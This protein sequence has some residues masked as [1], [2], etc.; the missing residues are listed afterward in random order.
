[1]TKRRRTPKKR[2]EHIPAV[3][4]EEEWRLLQFHPAPVIPM[5]I[6]QS[7]VGWVLVI[8]DLIS[9]VNTRR[10]YLGFLMSAILHRCDRTDW[11]SKQLRYHRELALQSCVLLA[12]LS[13]IL[14][15]DMALL[16]KSLDLPFLTLAC[17]RSDV[18]S[19]AAVTAMNIIMKNS[20][21]AGHLTRMLLR[22]I[23]QD[24]DLRERR[25]YYA[26]L[27]DSINQLSNM[28]HIKYKTRIQEVVSAGYQD[29]DTIIRK[30]ARLCSS[31]EGELIG[32]FSLDWLFSLATR[33]GTKH[34][35]NTDTTS[36]TAMNNL[37]H[38]HRN[39]PCLITR[40]EVDM[41]L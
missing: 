5:R 29:Q 39:Y 14:S 21:V 6:I 16:F 27:H 23:S 19:A 28:E 22:N 40:T 3:L 38:Y 9:L 30:Y 12:D 18:I 24:P 20:R 37:H 31:V 35:R 25:V 34:A 41:I 36:I 7:Y 11:H 1:M 15:R 33:I 32:G 17:S 2:E 13:T 26:L 4:N 10:K 8:P